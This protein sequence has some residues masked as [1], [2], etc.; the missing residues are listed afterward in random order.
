M[1]SDQETITFFFDFLRFGW[2]LYQNSELHNELLLHKPTQFTYSVNLVLWNNICNYVQRE[3]CPKMEPNVMWSFSEA[4]YVSLGWS[5]MEH[6]NIRFVK[7]CLVQYENESNFSFVFSKG[8]LGFIHLGF[9][10][11]WIRK[12]I[13]FNKLDDKKI[14][15]FLKNTG[16]SELRTPDLLT[17]QQS[18]MLTI[19][20]NK[21]AL[22]ERHR[23]TFTILQ[24][25]L[26]WFKLNSTNS[27]NKLYLIQNK[28]RRMSS[29]FSTLFG[30]LGMAMS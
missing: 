15:I 8:L 1:P 21:Q 14:V 30:L 29:V 5:I 13:K 6:K 24:S 3:C 20:L 7:F 18:G 16:L 19:I 12:L 27:S 2:T 10:R 22:S 25:W 17:D 11:F 26:T 23:N 4:L 9:F 28:K